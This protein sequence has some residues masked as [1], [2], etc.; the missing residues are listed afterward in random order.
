MA[1]PTRKKIKRQADLETIATLYLQGWKQTEIAQ[2]LGVSQQQ[3]SYD[4]KTLQS[5][6]AE[7]AARKIDEAKAEELAKID[8][9][10]RAYWDKWEESQGRFK[11]VT[12]DRE[13]MVIDQDNKV[14]KGAQ[15]VGVD[16]KDGEI[17][18]RSTRI[19]ERIGDP[20]FLDGVQW[21]ITQRCKILGINAP[22]KTENKLILPKQYV[23]LD[24]LL[25]EAGISEA[26]DKA[27]FEEIE[28][29]GEDADNDE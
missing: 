13:Q 26:S 19:E 8:R 17:V 2:E 29:D 12:V 6:W 11:S 24:E 9:L 4:L 25:A 10:E 20:K 27:A 14:H 15:R 21:C 16:G 5:R 18:R 22:T 3:I 28:N 23:G 1:K 7:T